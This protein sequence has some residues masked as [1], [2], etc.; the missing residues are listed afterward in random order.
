MIPD[1][2]LGR[3]DIRDMWLTLRRAVALAEFI[4]LQRVPYAGPDNPPDPR[5]ALFEVILA[6][7]STELRAKAVL[8]ANGFQGW[9]P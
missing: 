3:G 5:Y 2:Q 4:G 7:D 9:L 8:I 6:T 1:S